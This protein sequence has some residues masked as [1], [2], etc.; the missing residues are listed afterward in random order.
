MKIVVD[1]NIPGVD[2]TFSRH[3]E[4]VRVDGRLL[5]KHQLGQAKALIVRSVTPVNPDLLENTAIEFVGTTTIGTDHMDLAWLEQK[6]IHWASAPGCNADAAAQY[7]LSMMVLAGHRLGLRLKD[8]RVGIVGHGNVGSRVHR[9]LWAYGVKDIR[10]C[11][12]PLADDGQAGFCDTDEISTCNVIS[13]HVPLTSSGPYATAGMVDDPYLSRLQSGTLLLNASRGKVVEGRSLYEWLRAGRG[14]AALDVWP[15]E[16]N[17]DPAL[18]DAVTVATPHVA[19]HSLDGK[20]RG[21]EMI[22]GQFCKWLKTG[23]TN[24]GLVASL[25]LN[26]RPALPGSGLDDA[27]L[28]ACPVSRDDAQLRKLLAV[29]PQRRPAFFDALRREYPERRDFCGWEVPSNVPEELAK[30]LRSLGFH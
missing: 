12:P 16:P 27:I 2:T 14:F 30:T 15:G 5:Q 4:I 21:T 26:P 25:S 18:L 11:D 13:F 20:L 28:T 22:Y 29:E 6:G 8:L 9:L 24:P 23:Q 19:G 3:G 17:I 7:T 1:Q 10:A